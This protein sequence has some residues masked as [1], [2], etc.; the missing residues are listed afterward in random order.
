MFYKKGLEKNW[1]K[2]Y[3]KKINPKKNLQMKKL[4]NILKKVGLKGVGRRLQLSAGARKK[5]AVGRQF[6]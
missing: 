5:P 1:K 4:K 6:F 2:I 3:K